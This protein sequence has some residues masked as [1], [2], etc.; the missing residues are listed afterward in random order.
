MK[1]VILTILLFIMLLPFIVK[2]DSCD[3][4][5]VTIESIT[6]EE[7]TGNASEKSNATVTNN[8]INLDLS[9]NNVGDSVTY[10]VDVR[11]DSDEDMIVDEDAFNVIESDYIK[12]SLDSEE[13][14]LV[15]S[16]T[17]KA[18]FLKIEYKNKVPAT[19][20]TNEGYKEEEDLTLSLS[21]KETSIIEEIINPKTG[22]IRVIIVATILVISIFAYLIFSKEKPLTMVIIGMIL[23]IPVMTY[24]VCEIEI[25][26]KAKIEINKIAEFDTGIIVNNKMQILADNKDNIKS[27]NRSNTLPENI[28]T[29]VDD[30]LLEF[31][32]L[33]V[34][35][36]ELNIEIDRLKTE[37]KIYHTE[38]QNGTIVY[39]SIDSYERPY[40]YN[41][42]N[43]INSLR[44]V[45]VLLVKNQDSDEYNYLVYNYDTDGFILVDET[46]FRI[47]L[48]K[49]MFDEKKNQ[50]LKNVLSSDNSDYIIYGWYDDN[51]IYYYCENDKVYLNPNSSFMFYNAF[52]VESLP[53]IE[54][55]DTSHV[56]N[57]ASLFD[58]MAYSSSTID[59]DLSNWNTSK[60]TNMKYMFSYV[61][62]VATT[63]NI[64]GISNF[65]TSKVID[66]SHMFNNTGFSVQAFDLDLSNWDTSNVRTMESMFSN[67]GVRSSSWNVG[68]IGDWDVSNVTNMSGMFLDAADNSTSVSLDLSGWNTSNVT[69]MSRMFYFYGYRSTEYYLN[70]SNWNT[71]KVTDMHDMFNRA[72]NSAT[73]WS[74]D[75]LT[76]F[77]TSKVTNMNNMFAFAGSNA[78]IIDLDISR[79]NTSKVT[80]MF[81][82]FEC[83]G[84]NSNRFNLDL[85]SWDVGNV[86]LLS[87]FFLNAGQYASEWH[88]GDLSNWD[89]SSATSTDNMFAYSGQNA[90]N[91]YVGDLSNWDTSKVTHFYKMFLGAGQNA[92]TWNSIG[93]LKAYVNN[94]SQMFMDCPNAKAIL[95]IYVNPTSYSN[96]FKNAATS[97]DASIVVNYT[98]EVTNIDSIIATK[99]SNSH[100]VKGELLD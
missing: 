46:E 96:T 37:S 87:G 19:M 23:I 92:T 89:V 28:K 16:K 74:I 14:V 2:A 49:H 57:M 71:S 95:R 98:N 70:V 91:W 97:D 27:F 53:G 45:F 9:M 38:Q 26:I 35:D 41:D 88:V 85:S 59:I 32:N 68:N 33:V 55:V 62:D 83:T 61:G 93:G 4:E 1:K 66:M 82:M 8:N 63:M 39:C 42:N 13:S 18:I 7:S 60:V 81:H 99:S 90:P 11:N 94:I 72:G 50:L 56:V 22:D 76:S 12:Y 80:S 79:W 64:R 78:P 47:K 20:M 100:V 5:K 77:D 34:S 73:T 25:N 10:K 15:K 65:D 6:M 48:K 24:A 75:G 69:D 52:Y 86:T 31:N 30:S 44:N 51:K 17:K 43:I 40:C 84:M 58:G 29:I 67:T 3:V 54:N 21:A 36:D